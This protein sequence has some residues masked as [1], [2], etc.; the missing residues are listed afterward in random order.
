MQKSSRKGI[1]VLLKLALK[2]E[3]RNKSGYFN[4]VLYALGS[5]YIASLVFS[6]QVGLQVWNA[7][8]WFLLLFNAITA[9]SQ[10]FKQEAGV[11]FSY[12]YQIIRPSE[13]ML[14]KLI[15]NGIYS[16][17]VSFLQFALLIFFLGLPFEGALF[18]LMHLL[19]GALSLSSVLSMTAGIASRTGNNTALMSVLSF[20][21]L[22]PA[23]VL[24]LKGSLLAALDVPLFQSTTFLFAN[25]ALS[26]LVFALGYLL[27]PY[28]WSD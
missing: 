13:L 21:L 11:R 23:L 4:T 2:L 10:S 9:C 12:Y 17:W 28:L 16:A 7:L 3:W 22:I 18:Y 24:G 26:A 27:F 1:W 15:F 8:M 14:S 20:P 25:L 6:A 5:S 19:V